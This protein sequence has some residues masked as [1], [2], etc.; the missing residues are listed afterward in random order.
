[1]PPVQDQGSSPRLY[2]PQPLPPSRLW[3]SL[4]SSRLHSS[5]CDIHHH[6]RSRRISR[7]SLIRHTKNTFTN[8]YSSHHAEPKSS[9]S[10]GTTRRIRHTDPALLSSLHLLPPYSTTLQSACRSA[11]RKA[12]TFNSS[13][14]KPPTSSRASLTI[15][16]G[17]ALSSS[18]VTRRLPS[19]MLSSHWGHSIRHL[20][21]QPNHRPPRRPP[22]T[23][24]AET[25]PFGIGRSRSSNMPV[26]AVHWPFSVKTTI[27]VSG[28]A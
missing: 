26:R 4:Y 22:H 18:N 14:P 10:D 7:H 6:G 8:R 9:R 25:A 23:T 11:N 21:K 24:M 28:Q 15:S 16:F 17:H 5:H 19:A 1:M 20:R 2:H 12:Y 3:Q 13:A 27:T